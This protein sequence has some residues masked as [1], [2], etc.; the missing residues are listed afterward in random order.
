MSKVSGS[1]QYVTGQDQKTWC[2]T[3]LMPYSLD[4]LF[5]WCPT[6][7]MSNS[8][9]ALLT[10]C[11]TYLISYSLDI[12]L[13]WYPTH[14][15]SYSLDILL[16]WCPNHL[17]PHSLDVLLTWCPTH[18]MPYSLDALYTWCPTH[19][20]SSMVARFM[21]STLSMCIKSFTTL[22]FKKSGIWNTPSE[23]EEQAWTHWVNTS[24]NK[25]NYYDNYC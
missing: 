11:P 8:L 24:L 3:N 21:G 6:H 22:E 14:L 25:S 10:W 12:L 4:A 20:M 13:T 16:T 19:L 23:Q 7:L 2:P 9:D 18:L 17:M 15:I 5:T 1:A